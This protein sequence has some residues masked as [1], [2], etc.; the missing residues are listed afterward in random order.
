MWNEKNAVHFLCIPKWRVR[1]YIAPPKMKV[2]VYM[3]PQMKKPVGMLQI[4]YYSCHT[5]FR[6]HYSG[7]TCRRCSIQNLHYLFYTY[8]LNSI[9]IAQ[10]PA[11]TI[12][13][14]HG[15]QHAHDILIALY[16]DHTMYR[17]QF[18]DCAIFRLQSIQITQFS[19]YTQG[20]PHI[21]KTGWLDLRAK[22]GK[23]WETYE[24]Q[25]KF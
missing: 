3:Y 25:S 19:D 20:S 21:V 13:R 24:N 18:S 4:T 2:K 12:I 8:R 9:Q 16:S 22:W 10:Y 11:Y 15:I 23:I 17:L 1:G 5:V 14:F 7:Y 6:R